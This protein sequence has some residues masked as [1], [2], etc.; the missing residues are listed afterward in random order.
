MQIITSSSPLAYIRTCI[1]VRSPGASYDH[2]SLRNNV[3]R[4]IWTLASPAVIHP[5]RPSHRLPPKEVTSWGAASFQWK[6]S[7]LGSLLLLERKH[8][9]ISGYTWDLTHF[10]VN[11]TSKL[12]PAK[13]QLIAISTLWNILIPISRSQRKDNALVTPP[14]LPIYSLICL[15]S[16]HRKSPLVVILQVQVSLN[17]KPRNVTSIITPNARTIPRSSTP[18]MLNS[19]IHQVTIRG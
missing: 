12:K 15:S 1:L 19:C 14:K 17:C 2:V 18:Q 4:E 11:L 3:L 6:Q 10:L 16:S 8:C 5:L 9:V 13:F 7:L